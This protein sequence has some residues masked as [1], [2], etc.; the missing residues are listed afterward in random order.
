MKIQKVN[1]FIPYQNLSRP[2]YNQFKA[3][4]QNDSVSFQGLNIGKK[5]KMAVV[6]SM[7]M[8]LL[9]CSKT[10]EAVIASKQYLADNIIKTTTELLKKEGSY[11]IA[12]IP[13]KPEEETKNGVTQ[14][15]SSSTIKSID[16]AIQSCQE[17]GSKPEFINTGKTEPALGSDFWYSPANSYNIFQGFNI[18]CVH[19]KQKGIMKF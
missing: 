11:V 2:E 7:L 10:P 14:Y 17:I 1:S 5:G 6:A 9:G 15:L 3:C 8:S 18:D 12:S 4:K 19:S 13:V 16:K